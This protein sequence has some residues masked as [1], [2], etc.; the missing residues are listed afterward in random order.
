MST[1]ASA[2]V[3]RR[4]GRPS[5]IDR[6]RIV[7][8]GVALGLDGLSMQAVAD[9]LGVSAGALYGHVSDLAE[10]TGLVGERLRS[11]VERQLHTASDWRGWLREFAQVIRSDLGGS[12]ATLFG[13]SE[14]RPM[15][16]GIGEPGLD[17]LIDAGLHPVEAAHAVWLVVRLAATV[18]TADRPSFA[19]FLEPTRHV[20]E[21]GGRDGYPALSRIHHDL[22]DGHAP[23][24]F[25]F[26]LDLVLDGIAARLRDRS[27]E[28]ED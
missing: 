7:D 14:R 26:E 1:S 19:G 9:E 13:A 8:V 11:E 5:K 20:V 28:S 25:P 4:R 16:I 12:A 3:A 17:L 15:R 27:A 21:T 6:D 18:G 22:V 23:D 24:S 2:G 10:L